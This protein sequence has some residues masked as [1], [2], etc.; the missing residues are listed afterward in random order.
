MSTAPGRSSTP[1]AG[2]LA[3]DPASAAVLVFRTAAWQPVGT[4][5]GAVDQLG[6]NATA[7]ATN[8]LAVGSNAVLFTGIEAADGGTGDIRFIVNK[9]ADG[10]TASLLF[11]SGFSGRAEVGLAGDT[12]FVFKVSP[13]GSRL[14]RGDPHRQGH[15]PAGDPLRQRR[16][17][18]DRRDR[19]G[20]DRRTGRGQAGVAGGFAPR[21]VLAAQPDSITSAPDGSDSNDGLADTSGG[22]LRDDPAGS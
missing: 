21:E 18:P 19:P 20:R 22:R 10:D 17:G 2:W 9:E 3:F 12:D 5:L 6:V 4:F 8:R 1:P 7:D 13:N 15:R 14:D 16:L 11:Q